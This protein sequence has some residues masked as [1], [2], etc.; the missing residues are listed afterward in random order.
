ME[1]FSARQV[2]IDDP[3]WSPR[4]ETHTRHDP[5][6]SADLHPVCAGGE[7]GRVATE[8]LGQNIGV[9]H[10]VRRSWI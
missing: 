1:E 4:P 2:A 8:R 6:W 7:S 10:I 3:F 9:F 5:R